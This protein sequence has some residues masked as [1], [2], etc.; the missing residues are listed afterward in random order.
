MRR[1]ASFSSAIYDSGSIKSGID[2]AWTF[3]PPPRQF[4]RSSYAIAAGNRGNRM[5]LTPSPNWPDTGNNAWRLAS[6]TFVGLQSVP[7][8]TVL[9]GGIVK[10]KWAINSAFMSMYAFASVLCLGSVCLQHV[11]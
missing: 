7:G 3:K 4:V 2:L 9:Y 5:A 8:F 10:K 6:A 11:V 1:M